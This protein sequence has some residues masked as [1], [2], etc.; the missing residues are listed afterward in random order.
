MA[1]YDLYGFKGVAVLEAKSKVEERLSFSFEERESF[2]QGGRYYK[3]GGGESESFVL[4]GNIDP[5]DGEPVEQKFP[6]FPIL[7]YVDV[8][9]RS[10]EIKS[11]LGADFYLLRHELFD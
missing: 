6:D 9:L 7:L 3:F 11:L 1:A 2:Y 8:T 4:K 10:E 5:F